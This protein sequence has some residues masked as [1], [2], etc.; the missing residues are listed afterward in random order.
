MKSLIQF[1]GSRHLLASLAMI[2]VFVLGTGAAFNLKRTLFPNVELGELLIITRYPGAAPE[3]VEI[4]VTDRIEKELAGITN[5]KQVTSTSLENI[6]TV[7]IRINEDAS[8]IDEV[9]AEIREAVSRVTDLP[10]EVSDAPRII[11]VKT[12]VLPI[13]EVGVVGDVPYPQLREAARR[14]EKKLRAIPGVAQL[15]RYGYR[16][17]EVRVELSPGELENKQVS[18]AEVMAAIQGRNIRASAG[19]FESYTSEKN[20]VTLAQFRDPMEVKDVI[21]R[22]SFDGPKIRVRDLAVARNDFEDATM[23]AR[24]NGQRG[25]S[26]QVMKSEGTDILETVDAIHALMKAEEEILPKGL[27]LV[28]TADYSRFVRYRFDVVVSNGIMGLILVVVILALFLDIRTAF[29][30]AQGIPFTL[31]SVLWILSILGYDL[32][33]LSLAG[34]VIVIGIVVDD[35]IVV[36]E[37]IYRYREMGLAPLAS[38]V[39]GTTE[40]FLPVLTTVTTTLAAFAPMFFMTGAMGKFIF[41]I[42]LVIS[43]SLACSLIESLALL[44][45][46][47]IPGL[48][49]RQP[50]KSDSGQKLGWFSYVERAWARVLRFLLIFRYL[51]V[52]GAAAVF[53]G[54]LW[55]AKNRMD[56]ELF[57]TGNAEEFR[58]TA[59]LPSGSSLEA[60]EE[61]VKGIEQILE[62]LPKEELDSFVTR[63]GRLG[64]EYPADG[65]NYATVVVTLTPYSSRQR[66]ADEIVADVRAATGQLEGFVKIAYE[67]AAGGPPLGRPVEVRV[68]ASDDALRKRLADDVVAYLGTLNGVLDVVRDDRHGKDQIGIKLN[69]DKVAELGLTVAEIAQ[70]V[71]VAYDGQV[72]T[73]IRYGDEDV[74]FRVTLR[75]DARKSTRH[76]RKLLIPNRQGRL[77]PLETVATLDTTPGAHAFRHY[78][79]ERSITVEADVDK[80]K[81][82]P[83]EAMNAVSSHFDLDRDYPG[84]RLIAG[85]EAQETEKSVR[86]L[87]VTFAYA[88]IGIYFMLALLFGSLMQPFMVLVSIPFGLVA[89]IATFALH[90][91]PLGFVA[92][93]GVVGLAGVVVNDALVLVD[94]INMLRERE[95]YANPLDLVSRGSADRLRAVILTTITT[96]A[97]VLPLAY[98]IGGADPLMAPMALAIGYGLLFATPVTLLLLPCLYGIG[99]DFRRIWRWV[100]RKGVKP[101]VAAP[102]AATKPEPQVSGD[103]TM[104]LNRRAIFR[105]PDEG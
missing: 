51:I 37:N 64:V 77:I 104:Q 69:Y 11:E 78:D 55:Y 80:N 89:V 50:K 10:P 31:M 72:V 100:I 70:N 43:L 94:Y 97:G 4:N 46:H 20:V 79:R 61:K 34:F 59:E 24:I 84:A 23:L 45:A 73:S 81:T 22:A 28:S 44:P 21:V 36:S 57:P 65:G 30:V 40:V 38:A 53:V 63:V 19:T 26:F 29:W 93:L 39:R 5:L 49:R 56:F 74:T 42:P 1:F 67:I 98:G 14:F 83:V 66:T 18:I 25:I 75:E 87:A 85:G 7:R 92:M 95:P 27:K 71:R 52:V 82:T 88:L 54:A 35:A 101:A 6:S 17:R 99:S 41:V 68:V 16:A 105:D 60:T 15:E 9:I 90:H 48:R 102:A 32:D 62:K 8:D 58:I 96:V 33:A 3:D 2:M 13:L 91:E 12:S 47:L 86:N 76:L 103:E